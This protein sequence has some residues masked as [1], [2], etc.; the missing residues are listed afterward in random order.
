[1]TG[2]D[3]RVN[4]PQHELGLLEGAPQHRMSGATGL[5]SG[6]PGRKPP[7]ERVPPDDGE[8]D[9]IELILARARQQKNDAAGAEEAAL[10][11]LAR[12]PRHDAAELSLARARL[13]R[14]DPAAAEAAALRVLARNPQHDAAELI[15]AYARQ[16]RDD[17]AGA[18]E[19]ARRVLARKPELDEAEMIVARARL[20]VHDASAAEEAALRILARNPQFAP[21][22]M[23]AVQAAKWQGDIDKAVGHYR[24]LAA[25]APDDVRW[26]LRIAEVLNLGGRVQESRRELESIGARW[27]ANRLVAHYLEHASLDEAAI[28]AVRGPEPSPRAA[29][30]ARNHARRWQTDR[31]RAL[32]E[33]SPSDAELARPLVVNR[34]D[35]DVLVAECPGADTAVIVFAGAADKVALPLALFDRYLAALGLSA[36]YLKDFRRILFV[37]G[38][39]SLG[40]DYGDTVA[41]LRAIERRL[42]V[43]RVCT[44]GNSG[45]GRAAIRYG[46]D[47]GADHIV[48]IAGATG[49]A[50]C[51]AATPDNQIITRNTL[52]HAGPETL[53]L[54]VFL[55]ARR[56]ESQIALV[57]GVGAGEEDAARHLSGLAGVSLHPV[58]GPP[59]TMLSLVRQ[60]DFVGT[61]SR[62]LGIGPA[63]SEPRA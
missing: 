55:Q 39:Q 38:V 7:A 54:R 26:P 34:P 22:A 3:I 45:G 2:L 18:E 46:I 10:R 12:N 41:A 29:A 53:D 42:N 47:L 43:E 60:G 15:L 59:P 30:D 31:F 13:R 8:P 24:R 27:P 23:I 6:A 16:Q 32:A 57:H 17:A 63:R 14:N 44:I 48:S 58:P 25:I 50:P 51:L 35:S 20:Q 28:E 5:K 11:I 33:A 36:V 62:L 40:N 61:L 4:R 21:A 9:K 52:A 37:R 49:P 19:I 56:H 1:L